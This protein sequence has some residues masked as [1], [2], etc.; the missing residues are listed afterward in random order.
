MS[1]FPETQDYT[2]INGGTMH[3]QKITINV[4]PENKL[5][6]LSHS[7]F[8]G[9]DPEFG[10]ADKAIATVLGVYDRLRCQPPV[11]PD[12]ESSQ[13][14]INHDNQSISVLPELS[15]EYV[16][17][18]QIKVTYQCD[19]NDDS[20]REN[21]DAGLAL[22]LGIDFFNWLNKQLP[23]V[24]EAT[25]KKAKEDAELAERAALYP[26]VSPDAAYFVLSDCE[27]PE[28]IVFDSVSA[29]ESEQ[30]YV[31]VFNAKGEI[32]ERYK[33]VDNTG[34]PKA[35]PKDFVGYTTNF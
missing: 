24:A 18:E 11:A 4:S 29:F 23:A 1:Q 9:Y 34:D 20:K 25:L 7:Y 35:T 6:E 16:L 15:T 8:R 30:D 22:G 27:Y 2:I 28:K 31:D 12:T 21:E 14:V 10:D 13:W 26:V 33:Y 19:P 5:K 17:T 3:G 32:L